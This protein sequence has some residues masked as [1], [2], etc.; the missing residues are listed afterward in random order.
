M[1]AESPDRASHL[2]DLSD[3]ADHHSWNNPSETAGHDQPRS[4]YMSTISSSPTFAKR[5][6]LSHWPTALG[7]AAALFQILTGLSTEAVAL[8]VTLAASCYLASAS[9]ERRW[10]AWVGIPLAAAVVMI[11]ELSGFPWWTGVAAYSLVLLAIGAIRSAP[12]SALAAQG[13][14]LLGF[15]G[16]A[17]ISLMVSH[18]VGLILAGLALAA[19]AAWDYRH[20]RRNDVVSRSLAEFC[21]VLDLLFGGAAIALA[22]S[23]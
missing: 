10:I 19:H 20:W 16:I 4:L 8:T 6:L 13:L 5:T 12:A 23:M 7:L 3:R 18:Q 14:A 2:A 11:T 9:F 22:L 21:M 17:V 1:V 15:G